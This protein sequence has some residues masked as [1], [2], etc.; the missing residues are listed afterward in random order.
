MEGDAHLESLEVLRDNGIYGATFL[1]SNRL[2]A[3]EQ[4]A[5][6]RNKVDGISNFDLLRLENGKYI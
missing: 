5:V 1:T 6:N 4:L 3:L 2:G